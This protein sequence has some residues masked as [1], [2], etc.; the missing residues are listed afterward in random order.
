[1]RKVALIT[2]ASSGLGRELARVHASHGGDLVLV[3]RRTDRLQELKEELETTHRVKVFILSQDLSHPT[4]A[5]M[6][7]DTLQAEGIQIDYLI[8]NAGL[9]GQGSFAERTMEEDMNLLSVDI[10]A[11]TRLTKLFLP[12]FLKRKSGRILNVSSTASLTPG[13]YQATYFAAKAYVTSLSEALW[14][15][16]RGTGITVTCV[17]PGGL[18]TEFGAQAG[19]EGTGLA[20]ALIQSPYKVAIDSYQAMLRGKRRIISGVTWPQRLALKMIP[21]MPKILI[22]VA[23][24]GLNKKEA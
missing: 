18:S 19:L 16:T 9:G 3:A 2:G 15:E 7:Y 12:D 11:L 13:P 17:L 10:I 24:L 21:F 1:M 6:I 8:N 4:A 14:M 23:A 20:Q 22:L 5:R